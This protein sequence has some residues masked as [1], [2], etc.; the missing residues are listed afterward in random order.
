MI[1]IFQNG[2]SA[3]CIVELEKITKYNKK[4]FWEEI[5]EKHCNFSCIWNQNCS[6]CNEAVTVEL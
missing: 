4:K 2:E 1:M 5:E 6:S 3:N